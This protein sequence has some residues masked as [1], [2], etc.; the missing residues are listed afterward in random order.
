MTVLTICRVR[1]VVVVVAAV[2]LMMVSMVVHWR[3]TMRGHV[4]S[5]FDSEIRIIELGIVESLPASLYLSMFII[6]LFYFA[7]AVRGM[8]WPVCRLSV[9]ASMN[10]WICRNKI[11]ANLFTERSPMSPLLWP[12][13]LPSLRMSLMMMRFRGSQVNRWP[14]SQVVE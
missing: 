10:L 11:N 4:V 14:S 9:S 13:T 6:A 2:V 8:S 5:A 7:L 1:I 3:R 12:P